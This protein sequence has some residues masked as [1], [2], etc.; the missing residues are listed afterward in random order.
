MQV[1]STSPDGHIAGVL[2]N[3]T[4]VLIAFRPGSYGRYSESVL[5]DQLGALARLLWAGRTREYN[6]A[7]SEAFG[8]TITGESPAISERDRYYR[9]AREELVAEGMSGDGLVYVGVQGMRTWAVRVADG[10]IRELD[11]HEFA[12]R[13][14]EASHAMINDQF[15]KIRQLKNYCYADEV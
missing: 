6:A 11:E 2:R 14:Y 8:E 9:A 4:E 13:V 7:L 3:R 5:A 12:T 10:T 15:G 1:T